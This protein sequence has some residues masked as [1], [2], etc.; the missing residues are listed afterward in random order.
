MAEHGHEGP[1]I[2]VSMDGLG[3][4]TDGKLWGGEVLVCDYAGFRR[5]AHLE[6]LPLAGGALAIQRPARTAAGWVLALLGEGGL[7]RARSLGLDIDEDEATAVAQQVAAGLNAPLTS[8]CGR[9]FDAVAALA[10]LRSRITYE[11]QAAIELEMV[12]SAG[13]EPYPFAVEG[14]VSL[15][16]WT[17]GAEA[18]G[19][20]AGAPP[21]VVRLA[22]LLAAVLDDLE[23]GREPDVVGS[24]L[25]AAVAA[26]V[27]D[28]CRQLR[29][30]G[31]PPTVALSG[32]VFQN[33]LLSGLCESA[34]VDGGFT[35]LTHALV[36]A[37]D[38]G[39]SLGQAVIA[40]YTE[41]KAGG[42]SSA[43]PA[44]AD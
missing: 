20:D 34:L 14:E 42:A 25:H 15:G 26:L 4:G 12:S 13:A 24:R 30:A 7:E 35:V 17:P 40:G 37:N 2:G 44:S 28:L 29:D 41:V 27:L 6:Y 32:G 31:A 11:G 10:G 8:S 1:L 36:P 5:A 22:P 38:G 9:L 21:A 43:A 18:L 3:Y 23:R 16:A 19:G 39:L 33:R